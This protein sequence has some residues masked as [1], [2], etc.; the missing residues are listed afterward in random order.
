MLVY[1]KIRAKVVD[2]IMVLY[3]EGE[4]MRSYV[5]SE[6]YEAEQGARYDEKIET[7]KRLLQMK[8]LSYDDIA[9]GSGLTVEEVEELAGDLQLA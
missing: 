7:A 6:R 3:D 1:V 4:I 5:E 2:I 8:K 9:V